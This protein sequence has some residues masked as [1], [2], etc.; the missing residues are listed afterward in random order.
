[1]KRVFV[2]LRVGVLLVCLGC[3]SQSAPPMADQADQ[4]GLAQIDPVI[5]ITSVYKV[6]QQDKMAYTIVN[7]AYVQA[8]AEAGG[9]PVVLP[10]IDDDRILRRY[11][12]SLDG[13][14][15]VGG[16]DV[17][18]SAYGQQPHQTVKLLPLQRYDFERKLI[19]LWLA[20]GKPILGICLGMQFANV[21]AGGTLIQDIP[22]QIG[23]QVDHRA[24]HTV[25]I[26]PTSSLANLL[27]AEQARVFSSHH[28]AVSDL[29][30][31]LIVAARSE[32]GIIEALERVDGGFGL[33]VQWHPE[34]TNDFRH[35]DAIFGALVRAAYSAEAAAKAGSA[36]RK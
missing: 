9:V 21:V 29:G 16:D 31:G 26:V 3:Q 35:R 1:M 22:S 6:D 34:L 5:G 20:S 32:D 12:Q 19:A 24:Y 30:T 13:L 15:L 10:T 8:V 11:L 23:T 18:P 27:G 4:S 33:F 28:Q 7:F 2:I 25:K 14:V 17:P 36:S